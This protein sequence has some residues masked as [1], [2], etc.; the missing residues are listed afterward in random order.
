MSD[1]SHFL[2]VDNWVDAESRLGFT[3]LRPEAEPTAL[4][5]HVRDHKLREVQP[6]LEAYFA[7]YVLSQ[8]LRDP[9]EARRLARDQRYGPDPL[10]V[11][12][13]GLDGVAYELGQV[14]DPDDIDPRP[15]AVVT[16][17]DDELFVL[18]ASD[19]MTAA[20]LI[21]VAQSLYPAGDDP[22]APTPEA[23]GD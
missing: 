2:A 16:W 1:E 14:P 4:R 6:T 8:A 7:R 15:P 5:I 18:L 17:A 12:I 3:P 21:E 13:A 22:F 11:D 10:Q 20:Q 23:K 19:S 9:A